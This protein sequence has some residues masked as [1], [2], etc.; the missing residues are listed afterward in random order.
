MKWLPDHAPAYL[1]PSLPDMCLESKSDGACLVWFSI[2][3]LRVGE[4][5]SAPIWGGNRT[6]NEALRPKTAVLTPYEWSQPMRFLGRQK[7]E[8]YW[9]EIINSHVQVILNTN[10]E[11]KNS[12][13]YK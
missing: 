11:R 13:F 7:V 6:L 12:L 8:M 10:T 4:K 2:H 1:S 9:V 3:G 5:S